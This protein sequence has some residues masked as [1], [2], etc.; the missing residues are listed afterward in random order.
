V[1]GSAAL[2]GSAAPGGSAALGGGGQ[3]GGDGERSRWTEPGAFEV[4]PGVSRIPLPL[5]NDALRA[6]NVYAIRGD[7]A[8]VLIDSGWALA[9]ARNQLDDAL[10]AIGS[11]L[12]DVTRFLITHAHR[13]HYTQAVLLRREFGTRISLGTGERPSL[14]MYIAGR[15]RLAPQIARL[16]SCGADTVAELLRASIVGAPSGRAIWEMPDDWIATETGPAGWT[17]IA[18]PGRVLE[19]IPTPGHTRGHVCFRDAA[20]GLLFAGDHVLPH[21]TP[22]I[23]FEPAMARLPLGDYLQSLRLVRELPDSVLLPAH[24]PV[25]P[26]VHARVDELLAHHAARLDAV[27]AAVRSGAVTAGETAR[28]LT[29]TR[30]ERALDELDPFNQMLAVLETAAHLDLLVTQS[31]L[32]ATVDD[33]VTKYWVP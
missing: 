4:A 28:L 9:E 8:L 22:S 21:I 20:A 23:G 2:G 27:A 15:A 12:S 32:R 16:R 26:S 10:T 3:R 31:R 17:Q 11:T 1:G 7:D 33:D 24:G 13:D 6:V 19:V 14:E 18:M 25:S 5:P 30:R 29:W